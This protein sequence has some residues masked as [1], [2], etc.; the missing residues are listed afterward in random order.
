MESDKAWKKSFKI[1]EN[2]AININ[3]T[4][5]FNSVIVI[6]VGGSQSG[7]FGHNDEVKTVWKNGHFYLGAQKPPLEALLRFPIQK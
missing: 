3:V 1:L 4:K 7:N 2:F 6:G 5:L